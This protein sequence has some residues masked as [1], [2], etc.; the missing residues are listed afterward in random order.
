MAEIITVEEHIAEHYPNDQE[1]TD[2]LLKSYVRKEFKKNDLILRHGEI[3]DKLFYLEKG[4][5]VQKY[6]EVEE[7]IDRATSFNFEG[8]FFSAFESFEALTP[9]EYYLQCLEDCTICI[10]YREAYENVLSKGLRVHEI[11]HNYMVDMFVEQFKMATKLVAY[12]SDKMYE[13]IVNEC[14]KIIQRVPLKYI[15]EFM[16]I[17]NE[18][19]S[20]LRKKMANK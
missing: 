15:A 1:F 12:P 5:V 10:W 9:S 17:S 18:H 6:V 3:A 20:R 11:R 7:D 8:E 16:G 4:A 14:P 2:L 13:Y 19:L